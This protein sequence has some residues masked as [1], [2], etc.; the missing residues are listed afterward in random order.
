[1]QKCWTWAE[2][3]YLHG[4]GQRLG[5][6][7][8][9]VSPK[10][11]QPLPA[12][13]HPQHCCCSLLHQWTVLECF[14]V[15]W[16][17]SLGKEEIEKVTWGSQSSL[18]PPS[19]CTGSQNSGG[20]DK[21]PTIKLLGKEL[22][23]HNDM[24]CLHTATRHFLSSASGVC[25]LT[26]HF[27]SPFFPSTVDLCFLLKIRG[28]SSGHRTDFDSQTSMYINPPWQHQCITFPNTLSKT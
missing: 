2:E 28:R 18:S 21:L 15:T 9:A 26:Y 4:C 1:M 13:S 23:H 27:C 14:R 22:S 17:S 10:C 12:Q 19:P 20:S 8:R 5:R 16:K 24:T 11:N 25:L 7:S 6:T 3:K